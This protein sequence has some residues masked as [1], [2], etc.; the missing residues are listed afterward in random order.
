[1]QILS[2]FFSY[3]HKKIKLPFNPSNFSH[4]A[5]HGLEQKTFTQ[6]KLKCYHF[7]HYFY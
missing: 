1:M 5:R 3:E 7:E 2:N 6:G 4:F